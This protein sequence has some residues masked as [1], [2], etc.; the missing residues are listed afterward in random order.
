VAN[1]SRCV[2]VAAIAC[3]AVGAVPGAALASSR[4]Y[5]PQACSVYSYIG[6]K[7]VTSFHAKATVTHASEIDI[8]P[9][10]NEKITRTAKTVNVIKASASKSGGA[11]ASAGWLWGKVSAHF[12]VKVAHSGSHTTSRS[13]KVTDSVRNRS[14]HNEAF[15]AFDGITR[16]HGKYSTTICAHADKS[17]HGHTKLRVGAWTTYGGTPGSGIIECGKGGT[18]AMEQAALT[19]CT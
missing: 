11:S 8:G 1:R 15:I 19:Y 17:G 12:N 13:V 18:T 4:H 3:A 9:G 6:V 5:T 14:N 10:V 2:V 16:Y 7:K